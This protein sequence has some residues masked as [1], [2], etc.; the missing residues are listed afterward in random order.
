MKK[1]LSALLA[2]AIFLASLCGCKNEPE[3]PIDNP[4]PADDNIRVMPIEEPKPEWEYSE[5]I[6]DDGISIKAYN[7][8]DVVAAIPAEIDG[9]TVT[10]LGYYFEIKNDVT[11]TLKFPASIEEIPTDTIGANLTEFIVDE[12][13]ENYFSK[14]GCIF[15]KSYKESD[16]LI[17]CPQGIEGEFEV[18]DGTEAIRS[19]AFYGCAKI[20]AVKLPESIAY[21]GASAF[22]DCTSLK[23]AKIPEN[24][25]WIYSN[26]FRGCT[27]LETVE[28]HE[29]VYSI[30]A[31]AFEGTPFLE[32]LIEQDPLVVINGILV[33]GTTLKGEVVIPDTVET[34]A[35]K[36]FVSSLLDE[37]T[38]ITKV[39]L[40][41]SFTMVDNDAFSNCTALET[42]ILPEGLKYIEWC[43]FENCKS[44]KSIELPSGLEDISFNAFKGCTSLKSVDI[45]DGVKAIGM[46]A[47]ENCENLERVTVPDSVVRTDFG[48]CFYGCEKI[49]VTFKGVTYTAANIDEFYAAVEENAKGEAQ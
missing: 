31:H 19:G 26:L 38:E 21:I 23:S 22:C 18:P 48:G 14:N 1:R 27:S 33:D 3:P 32:K 20:T 5:N 29:D 49:N 36:A 10:R 41:E 46:D 43:A 44:L 17:K 25:T 37:N 42:V 45:P 12:G 35:P 28:I 13:N 11:K 9:K 15:V 6:F 7:G 16:E 2:S 40:P 8:N 24:I 34:I 30:D 47:F 39:T 4:A